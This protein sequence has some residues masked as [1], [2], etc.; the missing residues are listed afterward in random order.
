MGGKGDEGEVKKPSGKW[1]ESKTRDWF[2]IHE[3]SANLKASG[4]QLLDL[5][6]INNNK[7]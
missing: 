5:K 2:K 1:G 3:K 6:E 4:G 7:S